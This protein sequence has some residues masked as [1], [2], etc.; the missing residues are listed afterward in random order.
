MTDRLDAAIA[1]LRKLPDD[2]QDAVATL[3]LEEIASERRWDD[4]FASS[5][6]PLA[7]LAADAVREHRAGRT[8]PLDAS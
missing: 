6:A 1:E 7:G 8:Q 5:S 2:Q 3:I 4:R